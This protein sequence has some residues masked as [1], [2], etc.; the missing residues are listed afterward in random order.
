M[1]CLFAFSLSVINVHKQLDFEGLL[2]SVCCKFN[3]VI[4]EE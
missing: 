1:L 4:T 2:S 3:F